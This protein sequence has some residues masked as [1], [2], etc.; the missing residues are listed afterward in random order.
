MDLAAKIR[1]DP[2]FLI[3]KRQKDQ[4]LEVCDAWRCLEFA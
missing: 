1:E 3:K 4:I 2:M